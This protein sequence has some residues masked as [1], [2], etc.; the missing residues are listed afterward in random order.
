[1]S[2][3]LGKLVSGVADRGAHNLKNMEV[4]MDNLVKAATQAS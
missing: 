3:F 1:M 2:N 4:T